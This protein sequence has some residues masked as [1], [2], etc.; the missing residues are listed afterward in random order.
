LVSTCPSIQLISFTNGK[1]FIEAI[2]SLASEDLP[3]LIIL[4][5]NIPEMNGAEILQH[6]GQDNRYNHI[7][8]IVWSTS[9][10]DRFKNSSLQA[11][12]R[13]YIVKPSNLSGIQ[14]LADLFL[15]YSVAD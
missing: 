6:I 3:G 13:D 2:E 11:G 9:N 10:S 8:K 4:D 1:K 12:A 14:A 15:T 7:V 5:Y